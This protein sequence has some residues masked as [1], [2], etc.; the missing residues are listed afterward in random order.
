[1][2]TGIPEYFNVNSDGY[3]DVRVTL[4]VQGQAPYWEGTVDPS[5]HE[6]NLWIR[7]DPGNPPLVVTATTT[8][9]DVYADDAECLDTVTAVSYH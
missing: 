8:D 6:N 1:L 3:N 2:K 7:A 9:Y 4:A 5:D